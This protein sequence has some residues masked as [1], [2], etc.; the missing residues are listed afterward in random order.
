MP[1]GPGQ[2]PQQ[3]TGRNGDPPVE[4][5]ARTWES[6]RDSGDA[7]RRSAAPR[8]GSKARAK[9][10]RALRAARARQAAERKKP[11]AKK[12]AAKPPAAG[13]AGA[14][15]ATTA[16]PGS[17]ETAKPA[18]SAAA[19]DPAKPVKSAKSAKSAR[20]AA[21]AGST[22]SAAVTMPTKAADTVRIKVP[23]K[24]SGE[25]TTPTAKRAPATKP[26]AKKPAAKKPA[27]KKPAAPAQAPPKPAST[28]Q[29][30][31]KQAPKKQAPD[32]QTAPEQA[33]DHQAAPKQTDKKAGQ[34]PVTGRPSDAQTQ[35]K[36]AAAP[37]KTAP[38]EPAATGVPA[39]RNSSAS[40]QTSRRRQFGKALLIAAAV[41]TL[42]S[43]GAVIWFGGSTTEVTAPPPE[44]EPQP[45]FD[46]SVAPA[47]PGN[48]VRTRL[49][50]NGQLNSDQFIVSEK[51]VENLTLALRPMTAYRDVA[52]DVQRLE[53]FADGREVSVDGVQLTGSTPN[54]IPLGD[55]TTVIHLRY[56]TDGVTVP[57]TPSSTGRALV[58]TNPLVA[59][60]DA[61]QQPAVVRLAGTEVLSLSCVRGRQ[62]PQPCGRPDDVGW[63]VQMDPADGSS[64]VLAQVNLP[65]A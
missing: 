24:P 50:P 35:P 36:V 32:K 65:T 11:A 4:P 13:V 26:A 48:Y 29:V 55:P 8:S 33:P 49:T 19:A 6:V 3:R 57:S 30:A 59:Q 22:K 1:A 9:Q 43:A 47:D 41:I 12:P 5:A 44:P 40:A 10:E 16:A 52:P 17:P 64:G 51:P 34:A 28:S 18:A 58:L 46:A 15:K 54:S 21:A 27:A 31:P 7:A 62:V 60:V 14:T 63:R 25:Q 39:A 53:I 2:D 45:T 56:V 23:A 61:R 38:K 42:V 20:P 37:T